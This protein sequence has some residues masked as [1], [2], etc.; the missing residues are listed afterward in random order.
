MEEISVLIPIYN[1]YGII[2]SSVR[3]LVD[4]LSERSDDFEIVL[5]DDGSKDES[6][7]VMHR[8]SQRFPQVRCFYNQCNRGLGYTLRSMFKDCTGESIV[9]CDCDL[10]F[11]AEI[12]PRM[13]S[14]L[15][16]YD[17]VVASRY[18]GIS[19]KGS[20][21]RK[22]F[23]RMYY[24]LCKLLFNIPVLDIGSGTVAMKRNIVEQLMFYSDGFDIHAEFYVSAAD[25]GFSIK[26]IPASAK[27]N[28]AGSFSIL[29]HSAA[30]IKGTFRLWTRRQT[31]R[32]DL[33][34]LP[35]AK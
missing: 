24:M 7:Y 15:S 11:G 31:Q 4:V 19:S 32:R 17:I 3:R 20:L 16:A 23:S 21:I 29:R 6:N 34:F 1:S 13:V 10:P 30:V 33:L 35:Y 22:F 8:L 26:E 27:D 14:E 18:K 9:Y 28:Y 25:A 5:R 2:E 12:I